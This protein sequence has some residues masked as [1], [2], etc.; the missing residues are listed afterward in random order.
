M[1]DARTSLADRW[2]AAWS[3]PDAEALVALFAPGGTFAEAVL[4]GEVP[5]SDLPRVVAALRTPFPD[6]RFERRTLVGDAQRLCIEW[7]FHAEHRG[8]FRPGIEPTGRTV[9]LQGVDVLEL[10]GD[11]IRTA[12]RHFDQTSL[13]E[14]LGLEVIVQP[15]AQGRAEYGY[16]M[17]VPSGHDGPPGVLGLTWIQAADESEKQRIREHARQNVRDF[18]EEPG[19][20]SIVT[21]FTG[22]RGFT[23]TAW[24]DEESMGRALAKHHAVAKNELLTQDFVASV[25]TSVWRPV[26]I[27]RLW[28]R[29]TSCRKLNDASD[30][31]RAC[32]HCGAMLP[33]RPGYW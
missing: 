2:L 6:A 9:T 26:R 13:A 22:L 24:K 3:S 31:H 27:N 32:T 14:A 10:D 21:G 30:G 4:H 17:R 29:C 28:V 23:V 16:S 19:F 8:P 12:R 5:A 11:R 33:E 15:H 20:I 7:T 18:V 25:W 1:S